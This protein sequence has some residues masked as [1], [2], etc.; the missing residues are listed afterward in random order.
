[1]NES[2][3]Y[4]IAVTHNKING[5]EGSI[6]CVN[7]FCFEGPILLNNK[8]EGLENVIAYKTATGTTFIDFLYVVT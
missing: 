4:S 3:S 6:V 7:M 8:A 1:M 5:W 2:I